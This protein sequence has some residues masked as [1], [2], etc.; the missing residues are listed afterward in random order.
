MPPS[1]SRWR[2]VWAGVRVGEGVTL[3]A[4]VAVAWERED[5]RGSRD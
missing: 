4:G 5:W 2:S 3:G 1:G